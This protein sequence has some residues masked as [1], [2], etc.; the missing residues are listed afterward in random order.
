MHM[1]VSKVRIVLFLI[2][3]LIIIKVLSAF[4]HPRIEYIF[5]TKDM[6]NKGA[7]EVE[8]NGKG[9][10]IDNSIELENQLF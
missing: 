6:Q 8:I 5:E 7:I 10:Y 4:T 2:E 1:R 3:I 9:W